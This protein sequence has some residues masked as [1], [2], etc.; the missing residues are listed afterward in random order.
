M[1]ALRLISLLAVSPALISA[2][3]PSEEGSGQH[4]EHRKLEQ[5]SKHEEDSKSKVAIGSKLQDLKAS[6]ASLLNATEDPQIDDGVEI[7]DQWMD[8]LFNLLDEDGGGKIEKKEWEKHVPGEWATKFFT[9]LDADA[10]GDIDDSEFKKQWDPA[11]TEAFKDMGGGD[12]G[13]ID[14][15]EADKDMK[16]KLGGGLKDA[17]VKFANEDLMGDGDMKCKGK[18]LDRSGFEEWCYTYMFYQALDPTNKDE[19]LTHEKFNEKLSGG[20]A[21]K[22][23]PL[24]E[25]F[26]K[27]DKEWKEKF[28]DDGLQMKELFVIENEN[29]VFKT[30][31]PELKND[32]PEKEIT[33]AKNE[34]EAL[35]LANGEQPP[36]SAS[37]RSSLAIAAVAVL[38]LQLLM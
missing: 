30:N 26:P 1:A 25:F 34:D 5:N 21:A 28:G 33:D 32:V 37:V 15:T 2:L 4:A 27:D 24:R 12:D 8:H 14:E 9:T 10:G 20:N 16:S 31:D 23:T 11:V 13:F 38:C 35:A 17:A 18:C 19:K 3:R 7:N 29:K 6:V 22:L 36:K